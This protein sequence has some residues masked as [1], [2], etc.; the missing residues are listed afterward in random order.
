M[1][2]FLFA[3]QGDTYK[4]DMYVGNVLPMKGRLVA[5]VM[6]DEFVLP[7]DVANF[8]SDVLYYLKDMEE[9]KIASPP[10]YL[11]SAQVV[12]VERLVD[13]MTRQVVPV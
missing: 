3:P 9:G 11:V 6:E 13:I 5:V 12:N 1:K 4:A 10:N 7:T 8:V 2:K